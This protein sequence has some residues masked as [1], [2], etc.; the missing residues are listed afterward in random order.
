VEVCLEGLFGREYQKLVSAIPAGFGPGRHRG[1]RELPW[2]KGQQSRGE[3]RVGAYRRS[4]M[5]LGRHLFPPGRTCSP[6]N[7]F[8]PVGSWPLSEAAPK[9][10]LGTYAG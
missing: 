2:E 1:N 8:P 10:R 4:S 9:I 5:L 7:L 3:L 6:P